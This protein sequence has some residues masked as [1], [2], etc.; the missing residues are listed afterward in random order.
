MPLPD[1]PNLPF[2]KKLAKD[3]LHELRRTDP[4]ARLVDAQR[5]VA[6]EHGFPGW[7][8]LRAEV[9]RRL[10]TSLP[11]RATRFFDAIRAGDGDQ[12]ER[13]LA[14][15]PAL[16]DARDQEGS[17]ALLAAVDAH[18]AALIPI[19]LRGGA[20]PHAVYAHSA[21]TP[22]SWAVTVLALDCAR[23]LVAGGVE[24]DLYSAAGLGDVAACA[25][26][27][28]PTGASERRPRSPAAPAMP[29]TARGCRVRPRPRPRS[30]PTRST[31]PPARGRRPR[32][33]SCSPTGPISRSVLSRSDR[34]ALGALRGRAGGGGP[35]AGGGRGPRAPR[36]RARLHA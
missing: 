19:L 34:A 32:S 7:R 31:W 6:R 22:L 17:T 10:A 12:A 1:R 33:A 23:A 8:A 2:L 16:A 4:A 28:A 36:S 3:R 26:S 9:E 25:P 14:E 35:P 27:S 21:H 20:D 13:L 18:R 24:P 11:D 30:W 29:P 15:D 5:L